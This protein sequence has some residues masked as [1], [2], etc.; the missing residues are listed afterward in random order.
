MKKVLFGGIFLSL[1]ALS[2]GKDG[3]DEDITPA[4]NYLHATAGSTWK[5]RTINN[6]TPGTPQEY[7]RTSTNRDTVINTR[8]Y[9]IYTNSSTGA[10]EY[11]GKSNDEYWIFQALPDQLGGS[12]VEN[13]YLKA[14]ASVNASWNQTYPFDVMGFSIS[15]KIVHKIVSKGGSRTV[16]GTVYNDVIDVQSDFSIT[17]V[18]PGVIT[19][20]TDIHNY[21]APKVGLIE[22]KIKIN[23]DIMGTPQNTDTQT[24]LL[25]S[26]LL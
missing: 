7:T 2:C 10:S 16:N 3:E 5:Y 11:N 17:G 1:M 19:Y 13:L 26:N 25:S 4:E 15:A 23:L 20:S 6:A 8:T 14:N 22:A 12:K 21:Y 9:H 18:P 24:T